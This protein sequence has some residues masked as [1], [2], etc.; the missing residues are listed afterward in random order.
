MIIVLFI[1]EGDWGVN[2]KRA[3]ANTEVMEYW[4]NPTAHDS[5]T[6]MSFRYRTFIFQP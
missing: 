1:L 2:A 5:T 6:P 4:G 3:R